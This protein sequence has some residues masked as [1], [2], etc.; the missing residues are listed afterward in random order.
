MLNFIASDMPTVY[1]GRKDIHSKLIEPNSEQISSGS[2][3]VWEYESQ[4][5]SLIHLPHIDMITLRK[6][7]PI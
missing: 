5:S 1:A 6:N 3:Y 4:L 7:I 2:H